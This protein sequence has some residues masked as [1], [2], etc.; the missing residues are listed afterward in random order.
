MASLTDVELY[1]L[2]N[3]LLRRVPRDCWGADWRTL[4]VVNRGLHNSLR[5]VVREIDR[6]NRRA[7]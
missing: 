1:R 2:H 4:Y 5:A 3:R 7:A 6:R